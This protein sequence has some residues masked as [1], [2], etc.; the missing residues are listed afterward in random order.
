[1]VVLYGGGGVVWVGGWMGGGVAWVGRW[2]GG[3]VD[4]W[5]ADWFNI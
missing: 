5:L 3:W 2:I 4:I 1:M